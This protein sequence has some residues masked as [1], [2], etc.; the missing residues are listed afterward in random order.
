M[1]AE[2]LNAYGRVINELRPPFFSAA[3]GWAYEPL[4]LYTYLTDIAPAP[5]DP[6][7]LFRSQLG[8]SGLGHAPG[9][10]VHALLLC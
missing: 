5:G 6:S 2:G 4:G 1:M 7:G 8:W 3:S 10:V 9:S